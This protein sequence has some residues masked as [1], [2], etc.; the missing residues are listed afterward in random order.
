MFKYRMVVVN[1]EKNI[2][3]L[4]PTAGTYIKSF[5][6]AMA[7][8]VVLYAVGATAKAVQDLRDNDD[9]HVVNEDT[10]ES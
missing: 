8:M 10:P 6:I 7:P 2:V 4:R 3:K 1:P 9:T 5:A